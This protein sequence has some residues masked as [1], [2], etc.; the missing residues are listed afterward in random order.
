MAKVK[1][2]CVCILSFVVLF[3]NLTVMPVYAADGYSDYLDSVIRMVQE[4]YYKDI[5][6]E[7][8]I[9]GALR[10]IFDKMDE[11]TVFYNVDEA[12]SFFSAMEGNYQ[13]IGVE[14]M[15][16]SEGA[17]VTRV[18]TNSPAEG[19]GILPDDI[20]VKVDGQDVKG[21][22]AQ[23]IANLIRGR[24][25]TFVEIG[26]IRGLS[27]EVVY[28]SV[29]RSVVNLSPVTWKF[30]DDVMYIKLES[31]SS[32][33]YSF[34]EKALKEAD[35]KG[36]AKL[37]LDLRNNLGGEVKQAVD[38]A[39]LLVRKGIITTLDFKSEDIM[40][41]VYKSYLEKP[42][43]VTAV[44]VNGNTASASEILAS[45][46]QD[47]GDGFLVGTKTFG[48]GVFQN[49]Y[50]ILSPSA[51]ERYK[52]LYGESIVDGYEWMNK[53]KV[54][55]FQSDIIGWTK[56][57]TGHYLTRNGKMIDGVGLKPDFQVE[58]YKLIEGIDVNNIKELKSSATVGINGVGNDVF[59]AEKILKIKGYDVDSPD[60]ILDAK[61]SDAL[62]KYQ[63][64]KGINVTGLLDNATRNQLNGDLNNLR[65]TIDRPFAKAI[66]LLDFFR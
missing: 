39:R 33:S 5:S 60:N 30:Y 17:L 1:R 52:N 57:T 42:K 20:I 19:A 46:I 53:H 41:A 35:N 6:E 25:G 34:F 23:D 59:S 10:G 40:D 58:D 47:S 66:E 50:P 11:Y 16:T 62:K 14:I 64:E 2:F 61:T 15:E 18:F 31:F 21:L 3:V 29:E 45:A 43:Y 13:G 56:I 49:I 55:V 63:A 54:Q 7:E 48:K 24:E 38:I 32:N 44:L 9:E 28:F 26:I 27:S 65:V 12:D 8:L 4:R 37:V 22:S 51:Y 36:I